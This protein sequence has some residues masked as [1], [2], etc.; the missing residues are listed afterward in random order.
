MEE[1][2]LKFFAYDH[3]REDLQAV[4]RLLAA[5]NQ[6][7]L[8]AIAQA[9]HGYPLTPRFEFFRERHPAGQAGCA[10]PTSDRHCGDVAARLACCALCGATSRSRYCQTALA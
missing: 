2:M 10:G 7:I 9:N 1:R 8:P 6:P 5:M 4:S 3:L